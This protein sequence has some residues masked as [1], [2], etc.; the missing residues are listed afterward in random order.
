MFSRT[1]IASSIR[2]PIASDRPM[3]DMMLSVKPNASSG[4][5]DVST[6]T[7]SAKPVMTG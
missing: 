7:G 6:D 1:T 5:K 4:A 2:M 3:S